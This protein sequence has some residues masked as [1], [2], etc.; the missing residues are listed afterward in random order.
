MQHEFFKKQEAEGKGIALE[1]F[2]ET[3]KSV[4][5]KYEETEHQETLKSAASA[6]RHCDVSEPSEPTMGPLSKSRNDAD[7][8]QPVSEVITPSLSEGKDGGAGELHQQL[9]Q[10]KQAERSATLGGNSALDY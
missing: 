9:G 6:K 7:T 1:E 5:T 10:D 8:I 2:S 3:M 4:F